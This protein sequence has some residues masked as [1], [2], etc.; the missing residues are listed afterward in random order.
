MN[1]A[2][3]IALTLYEAGWEI[4]PPPP[5]LKAGQNPPQRLFDNLTEQ[6]QSVLEGSISSLM[7]SKI[8]EPG[9]EV[10]RVLAKASETPE[11]PS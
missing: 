6:E 9:D 2:R 3:L 7:G 5:P 4:G 8:M 10:K 1:A 11:N